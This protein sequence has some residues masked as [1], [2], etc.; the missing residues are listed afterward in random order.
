MTLLT[1][2]ETPDNGVTTRGVCHLRGF[3]MD[4][5]SLSILGLFRFTLG[6]L[7][8]L[9]PNYFFLASTWHLGLVHDTHLWQLGGSTLF[10]RFDPS[11]RGGS[12]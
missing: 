10:V 1:V 3:S 9:P 2:H 6:H 8:F 4:K 12:T 11:Q 5:C 7:I